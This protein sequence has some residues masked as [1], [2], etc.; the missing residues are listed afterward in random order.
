MVDRGVAR[1]SGSRGEQGLG[2]GAG[3]AV[4]RG[5]AA[6]EQES[7]ALVSELWDRRL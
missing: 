1:D 6:T 4:V 3:S 2:F 7:G 5:A